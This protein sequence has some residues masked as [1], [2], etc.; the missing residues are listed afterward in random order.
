MIEGSLSGLLLVRNAYGVNEIVITDQL[1][2]K[3]SS[4]VVHDKVRAES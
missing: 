4:S 3:Q 1:L 2:I